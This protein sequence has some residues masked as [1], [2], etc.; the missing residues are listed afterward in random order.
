MA[1]VEKRNGGYRV[2]YRDPVGANRS[3]TF[4]RKA[5]AERFA[6]E[7]EVDMDRG[8]WLDP[9]K[10][11]TPLAEWAETFMSLGRTLSPTTQQTY[12]RDLDRYVLPRFGTYR[13]GRIPPEEIE[14]WLN[15]EL[16]DGLAPSSVH[17]HYRTLR[18]LLQTAVEKDRLLA[19]PCDRVRPPKVSKRE[20]GV[21]SW[22]QAIA[23]AEAHGERFRTMIYLAIDSGMRWSE[24]VGLRRKNVDVARRKVRVVE[25]LVQLDD[26]SWVRRPPKTSAGVRS[27]TISTAV[28]DMIAD[29][30]ERYIADDADALVFT[31]SAGHPISHSSFLT[32]HFKPAQQ[33]AGVSCRFHDLRH[34][35]VALAIAE[36]AHS[37][38][39]Q[40]R[41]GHSSITVTLDRYG[42]L[43]PELDES[44]AS[45][46]DAR[47]RA[48]RDS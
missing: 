13:L 4:R 38:T 22:E 5:D 8:A 18:R 25:Q 17:R 21:L 46:F 39:I 31:N 30:L 14:Q 7:V 15:D 27:V 29:H 19:N 11:D 6:R 24:L 16:A 43:F 3:R 37:K 40:A 44:L 48:S 34:T 35:S 32:H 33:R 42:H 36:G 26:R 23:L 12:R 1:S 20:M 28:A 2:R 9:R 41:M 10:A 47:L 45:A